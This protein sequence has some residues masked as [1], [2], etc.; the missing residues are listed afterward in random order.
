MSTPTIFLIHTKIF[1]TPTT[2]TTHATHVIQQTRKISVSRKDNDLTPAE[3]STIDTSLELI[4]DCAFQSYLSK[5]FQSWEYS[6]K[7]CSNWCHFDFIV[8]TSRHT[9]WLQDSEAAAPKASM[10][11]SFLKI[12]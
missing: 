7:Y 10:K 1:W 9:A 3:P 4:L 5:H 8:I 6:Q 11:E 12:S 2:Q